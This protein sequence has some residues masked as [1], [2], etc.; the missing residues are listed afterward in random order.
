MSSDYVRVTFIGLRAPG[1]IKAL[2]PTNDDIRDV[3]LVGDCGELDI[4]VDCIGSITVE[5][6]SAA[7]VRDWREA[8]ARTSDQ[9]EGP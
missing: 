2:P 8:P 4:V 1:D 5:D 6:I 7:E 9:G 3:L